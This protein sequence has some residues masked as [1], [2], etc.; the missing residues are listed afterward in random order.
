M[1][2]M[3]AALELSGSKS[4]ILSAQGPSLGIPTTESSFERNV[5]NLMMADKK[6]FVCS[7]KFKLV[8]LD[9]CDA[10]TKDAQF[11]LRRGELLMLQP[12]K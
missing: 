9:E 7:T 2:L 6:T 4:R 10:M 3:T 5:R 8:I 1:H 12:D 11:A